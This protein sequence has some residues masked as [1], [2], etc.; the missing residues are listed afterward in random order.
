MSIISTLPQDVAA[1]LRHWQSIPRIAQVPG[2]RDYLDSPPFALQPEVAIVDVLG[3][4]EM[5]FRLF[6]TG[7]SQLAGRDL[8]GADVLSNFVPEARAV[9]SKIA[10]AAVNVPCGYALRRDMRR[11]E[12]DIVAEGIGLPLLHEQSGRIALVGF[13]SVFAKET[14]LAEA[15]KP[16]FVTAVKLLGWIDVGPG[17]PNDSAAG[18]VTE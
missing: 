4:E 7:L 12:V 16:Q 15:N 14:T 11:G 8:T 6:G 13:S 3:P 2:M 1:F 10:W 9:A 18:T 5:R 17:V